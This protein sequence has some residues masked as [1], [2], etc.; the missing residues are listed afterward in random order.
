MQGKKWV[1]EY[2]H[3]NPDLEIKDTETNQ[4][5]Y[6]YQCEGSTIKIQEKEASP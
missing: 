6:I 5:V 2:V 3:G 1:V 4:S